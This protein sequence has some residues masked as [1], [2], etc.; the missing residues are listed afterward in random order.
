MR[1]RIWTVLAI[2]S[3]CGAWSNL[4]PAESI[5]GSAPTPRLFDAARLRTGSFVYRILEN[6]KEVAKI[7][8]T[9]RKRTDGNYD[10]TG[11]ATGGYSQ[12]WESTAT[13]SLQSISAMLLIG[14]GERQSSFRLKYDG[15]H[16]TGHAT[17]AGSVPDSKKAPSAPEEK[18][19]D[20]RLPAG[21]VDQRIDWAA[22]LASRLET[23][24]RFDFT[25]YDPWSGVSHVIGRVGE[26]ESIRVPAGTYEAYRVT[27]RIES[28]KGVEPYQLLA[29]KGSP[30]MSVREDFP[31]GMVSELVEIRDGE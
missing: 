22:V 6:G 3:S 17:R 7:T 29:T 25:V 9:V 13:S 19:I 31:S 4:L 10:F 5:K 24:Q 8:C 30:H 2:L 18:S 15:T 14:Q 27:Y 21:T 23:G 12:R 26:V 20:A 28:S 11:E 1:Q 16:V